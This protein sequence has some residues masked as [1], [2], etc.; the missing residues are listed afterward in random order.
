MGWRFRRSIKIIPGVRIN[1]GKKGTSVSVGGKG[2]TVNFSSKGTRYTVGLPGTGL[3]YSE[4]AKKKPHQNLAEP[5]TSKTDNNSIT[6][7]TI[8]F[9]IALIGVIAQQPIVYVIFGGWWILSF[10]IG[11]KNNKELEGRIEHNSALEFQDTGIK[12]LPEKRLVVD[13]GQ[14]QFEPQCPLVGTQKIY[15][16]GNMASIEIGSE[17]FSDVI[18]M[19]K[20]ELAGSHIFICV[21]SYR[22]Y[23]KAPCGGYLS[24]NEI[25]EVIY[26]LGSDASITKFENNYIR[27]ECNKGHI[28]NNRATIKITDPNDKRKSGFSVE[29]DKTD[30]ARLNQ[31]LVSSVNYL[32]G[33]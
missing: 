7:K 18:I 19:M 32:K 11:G 13:A 22:N 14:Y 25:E 15:N 12:N 21:M 31:L 1:F 17:R 10:L 33:S 16:E 30:L 29:I 23:N 9:I 6:G 8:I 26:K 4:L 20:H 2:A 3:S 28:N 27:I 5:K 24:K